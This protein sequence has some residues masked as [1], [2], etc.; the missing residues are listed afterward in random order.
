[1]PI[2]TAMTVHAPAQSPRHARLALVGALIAGLL[3]LLAPAGAGAAVIIIGSPLSVPATLNTSA[4]LAYQGTNTAVPPSAEAPNGIFHTFH[5]G[6]DTALWNVAQASGSPSVPADGEVQKIALEGCAQ[7]APGGPAPLTQ[8]HFQDIAPLPGGGATVK[9][10]SGAFE[11]P[12]CGEGGAS[13]S[14]VSTYEP[15]GLCVSQGDYVDFN[16]E[17]GYVENIYRAGVPYEVL[18]SVAGST[19]DSF[20]RGG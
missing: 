11:I 13:G 7:A 1:M 9:L 8:I 12:V 14:T 15:N 4:N 18:G 17:G 3:L 2:Q 19:A 10:T 16:D 5:F 20:I 6:A